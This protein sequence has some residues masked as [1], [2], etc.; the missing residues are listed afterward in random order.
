MSIFSERED[1]A[2]DP[3]F[4]GMSWYEICEALDEYQRER[5]LEEAEREMMHD[6]W[7][8]ENRGWFKDYNPYNGSY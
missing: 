8:Y 1:N 2:P 3:D 4:E 5:E 6:M 7:L